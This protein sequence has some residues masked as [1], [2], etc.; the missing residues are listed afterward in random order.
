MDILKIEDVFS[1]LP[2]LAT[3]RLLLRKLRFEDAED[4]FDY[5]SDPEVAKDVTWF[6]HKSIEDS[7]AFI[8]FVMK[9]YDANQTS[10]W[11]VVLKETG[12][13]IGTCGFV[14][15]KPEHARAEIGYAMSRR[16]WGR[17]LMTEAAGAVMA[18]GFEKMKLNRLEARC[19]DT[20]LGSEKVMLKNG[21]KLE[22]VLREM[23][24]EKGAFRTL[25]TC[26]ILAS[27]YPAAGAGKRKK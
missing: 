6:P 2:D 26:S 9:K 17:G 3:P 7:R 12:K 10:E 16:Y 27:E 23:V 11:G 5:A 4:V 8:N 18:F 15:W 22:G 1:D 20:N 19:I 25:K 14:W 24:Y 13:L 21:M